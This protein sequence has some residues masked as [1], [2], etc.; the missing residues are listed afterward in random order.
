MND[1]LSH[2]QAI[3]DIAEKLENILEINIMPYHPLGK[4]KSKRIGKVYPLEEIDFAEKA[5]VDKWLEFIKENTGVPV[6]KG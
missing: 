3:A 1:R 6:K 4:S 2:L 5:Q